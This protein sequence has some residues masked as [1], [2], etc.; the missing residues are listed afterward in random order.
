MIDHFELEATGH[1]AVS[2]NRDMQAFPLLQRILEEIFGRTI[3]ASPTA[4]GVNAIGSAIV[5]DAVVSRAARNEICR[6]YMQAVV[7][8]ARGT[9]R[10]E[11]LEQLAVIMKKANLTV[12]QR[13]VVPLARAEAAK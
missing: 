2:Y 11:E 9:T 5:D 13:Q 8:E 10:P 7:G 12:D 6:R 3:Y 4:M 1:V